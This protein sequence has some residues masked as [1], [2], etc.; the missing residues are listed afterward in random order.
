LY[1]THGLTHQKI[2]D[3]VGLSRVQVTRMLAR[4]LKE[5][6]VEITVHSDETIFP[7]LQMALVQKFGLTK[8]WVSPTFE[9]QERTLDSLGAVAAQL[10]RTTVQSHDIVAVGLSVTLEHMIPHLPQSRVGATFVPALGSRPGGG[11]SVNPHEIASDLAE[12]FGGATRHLP[13]PFIMASEASA[14]MMRQEPDVVETLGLARKATIGLYGLG[15]TEPGSGP[16]IQAIG[17]SGE[18]EKLISEGAVGDISGIYF[19]RNGVY[20]PSSVEKRIIGLSLEEIMNIPQRI[21]VAGGKKKV[22]VIAAA[23]RSGVC[24]H[25]VTDQDTAEYLI[26]SE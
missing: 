11:V 12:K 23:A 13:A 18:L 7:D 16:L 4:A 26:K 5:G 8:A 17:P 1:Y 2:A 9:N 24:T 19:D 22:K 20:V 15:G 3:L 6:V 21:I 25:L 14:Q 10:L